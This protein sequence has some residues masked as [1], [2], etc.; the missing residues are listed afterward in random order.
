MVGRHLWINLDML[1][2]W[3]SVFVLYAVLLDCKSTFSNISLVHPVFFRM[4]WVRGGPRISLV[5]WVL[6]LLLF[7]MPLETK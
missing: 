7:V 4:Y 1:T 6:S 2:L 5:I 3:L